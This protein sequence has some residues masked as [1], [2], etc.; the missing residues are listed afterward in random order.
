[1]VFL[2]LATSSTLPLVTLYLVDQLHVGLSTV[3]LFFVGESLLGL[4]LGLLVGRL[5]DRW[6]SR[7]PAMRLASIWVAIGWLVFVVSPSLWLTL[8]VGAVFLSA[9]S[10]TMGQGFAA[11]H[12]VMVR[13]GEP[14]Q[15]LVNAT[16]R[17]GFSLGFVVGPLLGSQLA[18]LVSFRAAFLVAACLNLL[19]L[20][21]LYGLSV[22]VS[23]ATPGEP[24]EKGQAQSNTLLYVLVGLCT[25]VLTGTALKITYLPIDVTKHLGGS[26]RIYGTILAVSPIAELITMPAAG[27]LALRFRIGRLF[28][29]A[30]V[31]TVFEYLIL[32]FSTALWQVYL[33]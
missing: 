25:L 14:R 9:M 13:D 29:L 2:S 31:V 21:P 12:D 18:A 26:I 20:V 19:C 17:T 27:L 8:S 32:S 10:I 22:P 24:S 7:L 15:E 1:M 6:R 5:S 16:V 4:T 3:A 33:A 23:S 28:S 30:L 11:L